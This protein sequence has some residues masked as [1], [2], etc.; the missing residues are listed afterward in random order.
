VKLLVV[1]T[2]EELD[3]AEQTRVVLADSAH[4]ST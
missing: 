3:I 1:R 4:R 2:S